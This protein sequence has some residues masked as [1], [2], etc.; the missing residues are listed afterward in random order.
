MYYRSRESTRT[1]IAP[2]YYRDYRDDYYRE[3]PSDAYT[4]HYPSPSHVRDRSYSHDRDAVVGYYDETPYIAS[5]PVDFKLASTDPGGYR[6]LLLNECLRLLAGRKR[7]ISGFRGWASFLEKVVCWNLASAFVPP[8]HLSVLECPANASRQDRN[9]IDTTKD[10]HD[11][12]IYAFTIVTIIFLPLSAVASIFGMNTRDVRDMDYD[13]W[14]YWA[15]AIPVSVVVIFL[16]L[17]WT[18]ELGNIVRWIQSFGIRQQGYRSLPDDLYSDYY[19]TSPPPPPP[20]P[21]PGPRYPEDV[22]VVR[23][24]DYL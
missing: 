7:D 6:V 18:G 19:R 17:L 16:G 9:K 24:R 13:Q 14:V 5:V 15:A 10:R 11:N 23:E 1:K 21:V 4:R 8:E 22:I 2:D 12:A 3:G 20:V